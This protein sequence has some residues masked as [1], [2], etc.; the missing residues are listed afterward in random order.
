MARNCFEK[1]DNPTAGF[2]HGHQP[3]ENQPKISALKHYK[4]EEFSVEQLMN[5][6]TALEHD[7]MIEIR[8]RAKTAKKGRILI[9]G[10]A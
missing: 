9:V 10:A 1:H 8:P 3:G 4:L 7:V 6:A 5:F 2:P